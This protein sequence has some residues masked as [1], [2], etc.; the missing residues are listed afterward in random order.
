MKQRRSQNAIDSALPLPVTRRSRCTA[1]GA[2]GVHDQLA[3]TDPLLS[4]E[5]FHLLGEAIPPH[6]HAGCG[7][8]LYL[9]D[10]SNGALRSRNSHGAD[11]IVR[12]GDLLWLDA[13]C[14][15]VH[16][17]TPIAPDAVCRGLS[18]V[19]NRAGS[20]REG[21]PAQRAVAREQLPRWR[22]GDVALT[23]V[24]G[25]WQDRHGPLEPARHATLLILDWQ[26]DADLSLELDAER[27]WFALRLDGACRTAGVPLRE[28]RTQAARLPAGTC[29]LHG[30]RGARLAL[31]A[32]TPLHEPVVYRGA[33]AARDEAQLV[34]TLRRY[35]QGAM[36]TLPLSHA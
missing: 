26:A 23:L 20:Q 22:V 15:T 2:V 8:A 12:P 3:Q 32:G 5:S 13:N 19:L 9:F 1:F 16:Q 31:L 36:G 7:V 30:S 11:D 27:A 29:G 21:A 17:E 34:D 33:F 18:I 25:Q 28:S 4:F 24:F 10:D 14:G 35:Q 6:P